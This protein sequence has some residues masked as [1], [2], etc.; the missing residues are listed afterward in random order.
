M[1]EE[2]VGRGR[3]EEKIGE[4]DDGVEKKNGRL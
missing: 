1:V 3:R 4:E 2:A